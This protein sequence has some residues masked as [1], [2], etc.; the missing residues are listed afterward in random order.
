M[1]K[2]K[3]L[4]S[5][6]HF[7]KVWIKIKFRIMGDKMDSNASVFI[8]IDQYQD[9]NEIIKIIKARIAEGKDVLARI[10]NLKN[11]EDQEIEQWSA[12]LNDVERK[13]EFIDRTLFE[14]EV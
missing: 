14:P 13:M 5:T 2:E 6:R 7:S 9:V 3:S 10:N 12:E 4:S 1:S 8:K 11:R